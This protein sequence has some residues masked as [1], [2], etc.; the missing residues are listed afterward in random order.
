MGQTK[1]LGILMVPL[2]GDLTHAALA[3]RRLS[4]RE[5]I[6][7]VSV[8]GTIHAIVVARQVFFIGVPARALAHQLDARTRG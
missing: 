2:W 7:C 5:L 6:V 3:E 8:A 4:K 1:C